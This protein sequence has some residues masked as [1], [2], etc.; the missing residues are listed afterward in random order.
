MH[1]PLLLLALAAVAA[2]CTIHDTSAPGNLVA[3]TVDDDPTIPAL[4]VNGTRLHVESFGPAGAP[5]I[6]T[7][8][9]GPG[10]DYRYMLPLAD[11][12]APGSL[13]A[14]HRLVFW[15]QRSTGLSRREPEGSLS[16]DATLEPNGVLIAVLRVCNVSVAAL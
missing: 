5:V 9:G 1:R 4:D 14:D 2:S 16:I 7:I 11:A 6:L 3:A 15:D 12:A 10:S 13:V 8:H